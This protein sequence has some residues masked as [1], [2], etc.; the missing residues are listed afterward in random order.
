MNHYI[1]VRWKILGPMALILVLIITGLNIY[2]SNQQKERLL[3]LTEHQVIDIANGYMDSMNALMFSGAMGS[4]ELLREKIEKRDDVESVRMLRGEAVSKMFGPGY[5]NEKP[6]DDLD[7]RALAGEEI[8][9]QETIDGVRH[10]TLLQPFAAV[11]DR[12]GTNCLMCHQVPEGTILG[13]ARIQFS[14]ESRDNAI[15]KELAVNSIINLVAILIGLAIISFIMFKVVIKPLNRLKDTMTEIGENSD[16]RPRIELGPKDEFYLVGQATN[17]MLD[18]FQP[19]IHD[20]TRTMDN[21]SNSATQLA[22]V[23]RETSQGVDE[24]Q[25]ETQQLAQSINEL[26]NAAEEVARNTANAED[27]ARDAKERADSGKE[28][29]LHVARTNTTLARQVDEATQVVRKLAADTQ[30]IGN[31]SQAISDIAEQTNLLALNA[32]IEAARAGEQGRGF[33]VVA[34]EVRSLATRTQV[35]TDEIRS[36]I[37][38]L[39]QASEKAVSVMEASKQQADQS[40]H[41]ADDAGNALQEIADSVATIQQMNTMIAAA[42]SEQTA[43]VNE[44]NNNIQAISAVSEQTGQGAHRT[45]QQSEDIAAIAT[46]LDKTINRFKA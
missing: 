46:E 41:D 28:K 10:I 11:T 45:L 12:H 33:A 26:S 25:S 2:S 43:V 13:A 5:D 14:M 15:D 40:A 27:S 20:L 9:I 19:T 21:L 36:I 32:A 24:Q 8:L 6:V 4:R 39:A 29:V 16:L 3:R 35:S 30:S 44:I 38:Q 18:R 7:R 31:V 34:D 37:E 22:Q 42:A 1:S 17:N 23:T